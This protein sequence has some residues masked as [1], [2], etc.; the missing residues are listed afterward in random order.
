MVIGTRVATRRWFPDDGACRRRTVLSLASLLT[1]LDRPARAQLPWTPSRALRLVVTAVAG[2]TPDLICRLVG[3]GMRRSL[4]AILVDNRPGG[5]GTIG[6]SEVA[7]AQPDGHTLGY[8]NVVTMAINDSMLRR[9]PYVVERDFAP[10]A[11]LGFV[12]NAIL[13]HPTL[14]VRTLPQL[15]ARLRDAPGRLTY[16]SPGIGTTGHLAVELLRFLTGTELLHVPYRGSPQL[17]EALRQGE[18]DIA[19]DNLSSLAAVLRAGDACG[20]AVTGPQR[21]PLFPDLPTVEE[22][23]WPGFRITSWG[24][25]V[26]PASTPA[27]AVTRLN[28]AA[29]AALSLPD[30]MPR[31]AELA[32]EASPGPPQALFD[33]AAREKPAWAELIRRSGARAD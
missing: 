16:G 5:F 11:L 10:V 27:D 17:V 13:V 26:V 23:G 6:L 8:V 22:S 9:Q 3:E 12:Q 31:L 1:A 30:L 28:A 21:A 18:V 32:F 20:L 33:L 29:N 24:G 25:L 19:C 2:S 14:P 7:R 15:V 4:G